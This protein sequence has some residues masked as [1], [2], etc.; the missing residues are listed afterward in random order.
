MQGN[1]KWTRP[2]PLFWS[3]RDPEKKCLCTDTSIIP[4]HNRVI[5]LSNPKVTIWTRYKVIKKSKKE[6][7]TQWDL[8]RQIQPLVVRS[9]ASECKFKDLTN[10]TQRCSHRRLLGFH[11]IAFCSH[12]KIDSVERWFPVSL[13]SKLRWIAKIPDYDVT[14]LYIWCTLPCRKD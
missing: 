11:A 10:W 8:R 12:I 3:H 7:A 2:I 14:A 4:F 5:H 6:K 1:K 13:D 9:D